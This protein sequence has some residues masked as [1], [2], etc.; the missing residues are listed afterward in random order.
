MPSTLPDNVRELRA[1]PQL[2]F[3]LTIH[4]HN[5]LQGLRAFGGMLMQGL[6][7]QRA[8]A[9]LPEKI[10]QAMDTLELACGGPNAHSKPARENLETEVRASIGVM[11]QNEITGR[12]LA[13]IAGIPEPQFR[14]LIAN[15]DLGLCI[16][17]P[18]MPCPK[19][20]K[21]RIAVATPCTTCH[22]QRVVPRVFTPEERIQERAAIEAQFP[23]KGTPPVMGLV[24]D[25]GR[26]LPKA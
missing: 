24:D 21:S 16:V 18:V 7:E 11:E 20:A 15:A 23:P 8:R 14:A 19:C 4:E 13:F 6:L 5:F 2:V 17:D 26:P 22:G 10:E 25:R 12:A 1:R 3:L 9:E